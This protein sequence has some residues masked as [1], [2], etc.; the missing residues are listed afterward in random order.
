M[1]KLREAAGSYVGDAEK[2]SL[3]DA[4]ILAVAEGIV[5]HNLSQKTSRAVDFYGL[6]DGE[7]SE[8]VREKGGAV[9]QKGETK[10]N[11]SKF[12][13]LRRAANAASL[14]IGDLCADGA[15]FCKSLRGEWKASRKEAEG[16]QQEQ[17]PVRKAKKLGR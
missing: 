4:A 3:F 7:N 5:K 15:D 10:A 6:I 14:A 12:V 16:P 8:L 17:S 2:G 1:A 11:A 9:A 13:A